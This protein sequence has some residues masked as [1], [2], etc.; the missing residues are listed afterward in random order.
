M[1]LFLDAWGRLHQDI[2]AA[3]TVL[4]IGSGP[5]EEALRRQASQLGLPNVVFVG[6][7]TPAELP[8][9]YGLADVFVFPSLVDVWG[10]VVNEALACG[11]PVLASRYAGATQ[12]LVEPY[13]GIGEVIDPKDTAA[14]AKVLERWCCGE[15]SMVQGAPEQ[16]VATLNFDVTVN[17]ML[18]MVERLT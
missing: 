15:M 3:N 6:F 7:V 12:E 13:D 14:F 16:V 8:A 17:A 1:D 4:I 11:L 18:R 2:K 10:L 5:E 9:Y